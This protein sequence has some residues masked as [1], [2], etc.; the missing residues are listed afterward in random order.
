MPL[1][2]KR[3]GIPDVSQC[4][5]GFRKRGNWYH[6]R[7]SEEKSLDIVY[8]AES[9]DLKLLFCLHTFCNN[10]NIFRLKV[11]NQILQEVQPVFIR[12]N[13]V[14]KFNVQFYIF[15][16]KGEKNALTVM[17]CTKVVQCDSH[18][19]LMAE[20]FFVSQTEGTQLGNLRKLQDYVIHITA[21]PLDQF[22]CL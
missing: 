20:L 9:Q 5:Y 21:E 1:F 18:M 6:L 12:V 16:H 13:V 22:V 8:P 14:N 10:F 17:P 3:V 4:L 11:Y 2:S 15:R 7:P 19:I